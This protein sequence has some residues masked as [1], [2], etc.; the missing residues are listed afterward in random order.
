MPSDWLDFDGPDDPYRLA[1]WAYVA[2]YTKGSMPPSRRC[3]APEEWF[4]HEAGWHLK[5]GGM[6][7][8][9]GGSEEPPRPRGLAIH[10]WHPQVWDLHVWRGRDGVAIVAFDN[11]HERKGGKQLPGG[12]FFDAGKEHQH[13]PL[14]PRR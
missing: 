12:A 4:V 2:P 14:T 5:D 11:P 8:T 6:H 9:P 13:A 10:M 3:I 7:L 1:G